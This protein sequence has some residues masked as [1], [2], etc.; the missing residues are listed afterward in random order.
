MIG[1]M[2]INEASLEWSLKHIERFYTSDFFPESFEFDAIITQ[3]PAI[4]RYLLTVDLAKY[5]PKAPLQFLAPKAN[6]TFRVVH[7]LDPLD[8]LLYTALVYDVCRDIESDR[9]P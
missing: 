6:G 7:Q 8:A 5:T 2:Q 4:K 9:A 1:G 3:W